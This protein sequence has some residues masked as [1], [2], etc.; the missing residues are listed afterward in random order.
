MPLGPCVKHR[1]CSAPAAHRRSSASH[2]TASSRARNAAAAAACAARTSFA[3]PIATGSWHA[4]I[5]SSEYS[6]GGVETNEGKLS[7]QG[8]SSGR[9]TPARASRRRIAISADHGSPSSSACTLAS[10][11]SSAF[12]ASASSSSANTKLKGTLKIT[13]S[14]LSC[15]RATRLLPYG[16]SARA[17]RDS[18]PASLVTRE[19]QGRSDGAA[20]PVDARVATARGDADRE[21]TADLATAAAD[22]PAGDIDARMA[23]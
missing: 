10:L 9:S 7:I 1:L 22:V 18:K 14:G 6:S 20:S 5:A 8:L 19:S 3:S 13:S 12:R 17:T 21:R 11:V 2:P 23:H 4:S 15:L 16:P